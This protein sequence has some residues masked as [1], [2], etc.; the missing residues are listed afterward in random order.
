MATACSQRAFEVRRTAQG[1]FGGPLT[2]IR[3]ITPSFRALSMASAT[4]LISRPTFTAAFAVSI[5]LS[6]GNQAEQFSDID[7]IGFVDGQLFG[8]V[9]YFSTN[10][11][12]PL[13]NN[14]LG[15][16]T[17]PFM[18]LTAKA[19][20]RSQECTISYLTSAQRYW[21]YIIPVAEGLQPGVGAV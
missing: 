11:C 18:P 9:P 4:K 17:P 20:G 8:P 5:S 15:H 10:P 3:T 14:S 16:G 2:P 21:S 7:E 13:W 12:R 19:Q 1:A 6:L